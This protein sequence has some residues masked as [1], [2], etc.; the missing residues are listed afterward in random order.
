[1]VKNSAYIYKRDKLL[2]LSLKATFTLKGPHNGCENVPSFG[3][4]L[5]TKSSP[6]QCVIK[7]LSLF[8]KMAKKVEIVKFYS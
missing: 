6:P 2:Y 4:K 7:F 5:G 8:V 3:Y 1:M